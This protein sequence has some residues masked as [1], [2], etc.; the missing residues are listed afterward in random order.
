[1][2]DASGSPLKGRH[3]MLGVTGG[4]AAYKAVELAS[5][6]NREGALVDVVM[7]PAAQE[8]IRP[9]SFAAVTRRDVHCEIFAPYVSKPGHISLADQSELVILA[10]LTG[11][12]LA[13][14]AHG[15]ADNLLTST[16]L[17]CR[18]PLLIA[19]AMNDNMWGH[20]ATQENLRTVLGRGGVCQIGPED[21]PLACGRNG[22][23]RMSEPAAILAK[24]R[25]LIRSGI[26]NS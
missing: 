20:P 15:L 16:L 17:A 14:M 23:G 9:L 22:T 19:P 25:E 4:V 21:G 7:T 6:L 26:C 10:P 13:K 24:A 8:F 18:A 11:N 3:I 2:S 1:M 5:M 12:T